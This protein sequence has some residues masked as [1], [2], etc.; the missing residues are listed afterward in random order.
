[1]ETMPANVLSI[2][3]LERARTFLTY[4]HPVSLRGS[5]RSNIL[6]CTCLAVVF[7]AAGSNLMADP[8][9][10]SAPSEQTL[11]YTVVNGVTDSN[12][13]PTSSAS[14]CVEYTV[15]KRC[16]APPKHDPPFGVNAKAQQEKLASGGIFIVFT[17]E[18]KTGGGG[19]LSALAPLDDRDGQC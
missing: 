12:G 19:G 15:E 7:I 9:E 1:M 8:S 6:R 3:Q 5:R 4:M 16:Y 17:A 2:A 10:P 18:T 11:S 13:F 14:I